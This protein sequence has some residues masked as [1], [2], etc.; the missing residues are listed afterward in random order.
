MTDQLVE[1]GIAGFGYAFGEDQ[2]VATVAAD[3]VDD[4]ERPITWGYNT[5]HRAPDGVTASKMAATAATKALSEVGIA[6]EDLDLVVVAAS[7]MPEYP[8]WDTSAAVARELKIEKT[9]TLLLNEGC[10]CGVT[11]IGYVAGIMAIQPEIDTVMFIA[12][13]RVSEF[14]RNRMNVN[15]SVHS[16]GAV[17]TVWQRGHKELR[18]LSTEQ[19]TD[20]EFCDWFRT[21][22]G[23]MV[24]PVPPAGWSSRQSPAGHVAVQAHFAKDPKRLIAFSEQLNQRNVDVIDGALKRAGLGREDLK[25]II[26]IND[27]PDAIEDVARPFGI[28]LEHTNAELSVG[29]GHMGAA[30]QLIALGQHLQRGEIKTGDVVALCG[31]SIGMR[32]YC[33]LVQI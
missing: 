31:I 25:H 16:D 30:D 8:Y 10:A 4:P 26:Y 17:A 15:N 33:T 27:A 32:W 13:N 29:H 21:D 28:S 23:G 22:Y 11:G 24:E 12:V 18:W 3:Y 2:D 6:A 1:F 9:Q 5:F 14:H 20:P 19:F 7:E